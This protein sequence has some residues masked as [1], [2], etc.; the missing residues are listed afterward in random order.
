MTVPDQVSVQALARAF[1]KVKCLPGANP[2]HRYSP[3]HVDQDERYARSMLALVAAN[4]GLA[5]TPIPDRQPEGA[6]P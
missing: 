5:F 3:A 2:L 4:D 1:H 6:T